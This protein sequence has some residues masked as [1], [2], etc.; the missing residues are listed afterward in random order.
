MKMAPFAYHRPETIDEA[1]RLLGEHGGEGK[2]LAGGQSLI[3]LLAMRLA[4]PAHLVDIGF[5]HEL[6]S[7]TEEPD[8]GLLV[9]AAVRHIDAETS[10]VVGDRAPLVAAAMPHIGHRAIR[11]RGTVCGSLAHA[12]PAA[13]LPAVALAL[14]AEMVVRGP[15]GGRRV[16]AADFFAGYLTSALADDELLTAVRFPAWPAGTG[17]SV[18]EM[19]RRHG[20]F[21]IV[22][23]ATVLGCDP[24]GEIQRAAL[25]FFGAGSTP[26]RVFEAEQALVGR[27]PSPAVFEEAA[28]LVSE[29]L[30][31]PGDIH[32]SAAYRTHIAGVLTRRSL[33]NAHTNRFWSG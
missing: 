11:N 26:V 8:G 10:A 6:R 21:A 24:A 3:P 1:V 27:P 25:A 20:D 15:S 7:V 33:G 29:R 22:G 32:A 19:S 31:P 12:D 9:G 4:R 28:R 16:P 23:V 17:W 14:E 5:V 2:V 13:E 30:R 18:Q